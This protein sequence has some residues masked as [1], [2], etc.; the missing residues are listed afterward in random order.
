MLSEEILGGTRQVIAGLEALRGENQSLLDSLQEI[1][2]QRPAGETS[3]VE[4]E[5][6]GLIQQSLDRIELGLGEAQVSN[7]ASLC[8]EILIRGD[9]LPGAFTKIYHSALP[10]FL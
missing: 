7:R 2:Q 8:K 6:H 3:S 4:R 1:L 10:L 5:K 9:T